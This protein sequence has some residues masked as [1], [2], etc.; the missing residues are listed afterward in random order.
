MQPSGDKGD[1]QVEGDL[2]GSGMDLYEARRQQLHQVLASAR[3]NGSQKE[4]AEAAGISPKYLSRMLNEPGA[5]GHK[6]IGDDLAQRI[7]ANLGLDAGAILTPHLRGRAEPKRP[8]SMRWRFVAEAVAGELGRR[9]LRMDSAKFLLLVDLLAASISATA[10][11]AA[12][13]EH[14]RR[15][16]DVAA[17]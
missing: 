13:I 5:P 9:N 6:R 7:E 3:F 4:L 17:G 11:D 2:Y 14:V 8:E 12:V 15:H 1:P 10:T 16:V